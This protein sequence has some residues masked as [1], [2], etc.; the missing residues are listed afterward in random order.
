[1]VVQRRVFIVFAV[2]GFL[3]LFFLTTRCISAATNVVDDDYDD[4]KVNDGDVCHNCCQGGEEQAQERQEQRRSLKVVDYH[5]SLTDVLL[6]P[7][8]MELVG[9]LML[10]VL[11]RRQLP[12]PYAA[13]MF[14]VGAISGAV[15]VRGDPHTSTFTRSFDTWATMD[16]SLLLLVFLPGLLFADAIGTDFDLFQLALGQI[17]ILAFPMVL[18][19]TL[20]T[21]LVAWYVLPYEWTLGQVLTLG[22]ILASTDPIAVSSVLKTA[23]ASPRLVIHISGESLLNEYVQACVGVRELVFVKQRDCGRRDLKQVE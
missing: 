2:V 5:Q 13:C 18:V 17:L 11:T 8:I 23:G 1:M 16:G 22:A 7:W 4:V 10:F 19:G 9:V 20:L 3:V 15:A 14:I 12:L 21:G 6:F